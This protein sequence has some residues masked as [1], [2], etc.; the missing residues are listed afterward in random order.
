VGF[1]KGKS[2]TKKRVDELKPPVRV[3]WKTISSFRPEWDDTTITFDLRAGGTTRCS[4]SRIGV[5]SKPRRGTQLAPPCLRR[6]LIHP[7]VCHNPYQ[8]LADPAVR[9]QPRKSMDIHGGQQPDATRPAM[10][11]HR[12]ANTLRNHHHL[13]MGMRRSA[14]LRSSMESRGGSPMMPAKPR[15]GRR[16]PFADSAPRSRPGESGM[17]FSYGVILLQDLSCALAD[18]NARCHCVASRHAGHDGTVCYAKVVD[19]IDPEIATN[20]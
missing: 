15:P 19:S 14:L 9:A 11:I 13:N 6:K 12:F 1:Y 7:V 8:H 16:S 20:D 18:D 4:P 3:G 17:A 5:S 10:D 2:V